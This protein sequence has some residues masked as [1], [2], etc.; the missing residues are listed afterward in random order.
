MNTS[1][2]V[3]Y[4]AVRSAADFAEAAA[5]LNV[6]RSTLYTLLK[7]GALA[8]VKICGADENPVE[9]NHSILREPAE[10]P[11]PAARP[12]TGRPTVNG[13]TSSNTGTPP[14]PAPIAAATARDM[15]AETYRRAK[16]RLTGRRGSP[17][18][19]LCGGFGA[20]AN[21]PISIKRRTSR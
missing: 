20:A 16:E 5:A 4:R 9:R 1:I 19:H 6:K 7:S 14:A 3:A 2:E 13:D 17:L 15:D 10:C 21:H 18:D 8:S 12:E 11:L